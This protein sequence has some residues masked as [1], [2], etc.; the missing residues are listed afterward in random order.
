MYWI[1][2]C[3]GIPGKLI[4]D[5]GTAPS[6]PVVYTS[7]GRAVRRRM[8]LFFL[9]ISMF[10]VCQNCPCY[11]FEYFVT[12]YVPEYF[13]QKDSDRATSP[14]KHQFCTAAV[15]LYLIYYNKHSFLCIMLTN[16]VSAYDDYKFRRLQVFLNT[17]YAGCAKKAAFQLQISSLIS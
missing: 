1:I 9:R 8:C 2:V 16:F 14:E 6:T 5:Q 15:R 13:W 4:T 12:L 11:S 17:V 3:R 7:N 10:F